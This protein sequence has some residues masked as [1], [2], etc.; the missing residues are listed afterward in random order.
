MI[1]TGSVVRWISVSPRVCSEDDD[2][3]GERHDDGSDDADDD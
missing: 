2:L 3:S 1:G